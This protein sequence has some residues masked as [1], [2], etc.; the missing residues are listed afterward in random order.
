MHC[1]LLVRTGLLAWLLRCSG[2]PLS[3]GRAIS[4][5]LQHGFWILASLSCRLGETFF[6][7]YK[8]ISELRP[9]HP[10]Q[11][12]RIFVK[13]ESAYKLSSETVNDR[14]FP[15]TLSDFLFPQ[16]LIL[17]RYMSLLFHTQNMGGGD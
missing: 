13:H 1:W 8:L 16:E 9:L 15:S 17:K 12:Q 2:R 5:A 14:P 11:T 10:L 4:V 3:P 7:V 6:S